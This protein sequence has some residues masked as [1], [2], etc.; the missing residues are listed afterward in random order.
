LDIGWHCGLAESP[1]AGKEDYNKDVAAAHG[2]DPAA[3]T[4]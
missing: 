2:T 4:G 3:V 1:Q